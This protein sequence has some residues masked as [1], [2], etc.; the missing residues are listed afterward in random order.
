VHF[1]IH[2]DDLERAKAFYGA[3][4]GWTYEDYSAVSGSPYWGVVTGD[5]EQMG[6]NGGLLQRQGPRPAD[7]GGF[8]AYVC[9]I[10]V[11]DL[12]ATERLVVDHGGRVVSPKVALTGMAWQAYYA[13]SEGNVF[14]VHQPD[15]DAR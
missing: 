5:D 14:G 8:R 1:E 13:D 4:F 15:P 2:A 6:I 12:D 10:G 9:T 3:V 11:G 7:D